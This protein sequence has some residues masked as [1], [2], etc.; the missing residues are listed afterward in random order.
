[1]FKII[2][3]KIR[4]WKNS[5]ELQKSNWGREYGWYIEFEGKII[6]EL[7][8]CEFRDMFWD[9][10]KII[11][12]NDQW[13]SYLFDEKH[14]FESAFKFKNKHYNLYAPNPFTGGIGDLKISKQIEI[15]GLYLTS[16]G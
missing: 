8:D 5:R 13:G 2:R 9:R 14:W 1:M 16:I 11:P 4:S 10:Y 12:K 7:V 15:R 6:G 3:N